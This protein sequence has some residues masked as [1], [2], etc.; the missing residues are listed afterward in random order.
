[1]RELYKSVIKS[2]KNKNYSGTSVIDLILRERPHFV[3][4]KLKE[5]VNGNDDMMTMLGSLD[6]NIR[7]RVS[8]IDTEIIKEYFGSVFQSFRNF[9]LPGRRTQKFDTIP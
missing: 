1:M 9:I 5:P 2:K 7:L 6:E 3:S 8:V 4:L